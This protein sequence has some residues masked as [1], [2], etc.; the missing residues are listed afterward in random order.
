M[1]CHC[2][3]GVFARTSRERGK[4]DQLVGQMAVSGGSGVQ[5]L[6]ESTRN[7]VGNSLRFSARFACLIPRPTNS[8]CRLHPTMQEQRLSGQPLNLP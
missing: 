4:E 8:L 5:I 6:K 3:D 1:L 7:K 2:R